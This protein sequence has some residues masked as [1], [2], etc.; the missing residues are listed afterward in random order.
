M[1]DPTGD[2]PTGSD[3][4]AGPPVDTGAT[5]GSAPVPSEAGPT[6]SAL[7]GFMSV[8]VHPRFP[9][10]RS[11]LLMALAFIGFATLLYLYPAQSTVSGATATGSG[12]IVHTPSGDYFVPNA[13]KVVPSTTTTTLP[14]ATTTTRPFVTPTTGSGTTGSTTTSTST[15]STTTTVPGGGG[16]GATTT[17]TTTSTTT[18]SGG[19]GLGT[20]TTTTPR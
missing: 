8:P 11:T 18:R 3:D 9:I 2:A 15:T 6:H 12:T 10:R 16:S 20:T 13:V 17:T 14:V 5:A 19:T 4:Q 7:I 1:S